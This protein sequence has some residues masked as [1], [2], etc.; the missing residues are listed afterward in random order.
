M[1][2]F[3]GRSVVVTGAPT[4]WVPL[5]DQY[6]QSGG[7]RRGC[8]ASLL[9]G[10]LPLCRVRMLNIFFLFFLCYREKNTLTNHSVYD[11]LVHDLSE[12]GKHLRSFLLLQSLPTLDF[13]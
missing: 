8:L 13:Q 11:L 7:L 2:H 5:A 10:S 9:S 4:L 12:I 6:Q 1:T 3:G